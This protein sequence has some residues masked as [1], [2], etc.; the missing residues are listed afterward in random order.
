[1]ANLTPVPGWDDVF[2]LETT[3]QVLGGPGG[4]ANTPA[5]NLVNRTAFLGTSEGTTRVGHI[6]AGP[7]AASRLAQSKLRDAVS[8]FDYMTAAQIADVKAGTVV[9]D[10]TVPLQ[11]AI[12]AQSWGGTLY[13]PKGVYK[14]TAALVMKS[15]LNL[16]G[17]SN[18]DTVFGVNPFLPDSMPTMIWQE[19][20]GQHCISVISSGAGT[21]TYADLSIRRIAFHSRIGPAF[22]AQPIAGKYGIHF[23][24]TRPFSSYHMTIEECSFYHFER[25]ISVV[26]YDTGAGVDW[27][28]DNITVNRCKFNQNTNGIYLSTTNADA[29]LVSNCTWIIPPNGHGIYFDR[30]GYFTVL[31]GYGVPGYT[32]IGGVAANTSLF[33]VAHAGVGSSYHDIIAIIG[34][35]GSDNL[36]YFLRV[37]AGIGTGNNYS[38]IQLTSC[39]IEAACLIETRSTILSTGNRFLGLATVTGADCEI[40]SIN[41]KNSVAGSPWVLNGLRPTFNLF[42]T[43]LTETALATTNADSDLT[44]YTTKPVVLHV[45]ILTANISLNCL[46]TNAPRGARFLISRL[47]G[48][49]FNLNVR[50]AALAN[51]K[52]LTTNQWSEVLFNGTEWVLIASGSV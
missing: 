39:V 19:T 32:S 1:M 14:I 47:G 22:T 25:G 28:C 34:T 16:I 40:S 51:L 4:P 5:Q 33:T 44:W 3:T 48:G 20:A 10:V 6:A 37:L 18:L 24:G 42:P 52:V 29:W 11:A 27:Q 38:S 43:D 21:R 12:N 7:G 35:A 46:N 26:G 41:D 50:N 45:G 15:G 9:L 23:Y 36:T 13:F 30:I 49:A 8:V 31:S 2:Q 17:D